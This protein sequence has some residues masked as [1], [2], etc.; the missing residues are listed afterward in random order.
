MAL[1]VSANAN[2]VNIL[3]PGSNTIGVF[4]VTNNI[5]TGADMANFLTV[6]VI[7]ANGSTS[8]AIWMADCGALCGEAHN[9]AGT[10]SIGGT[11][12]PQWM[13]T[14]TDN[15]DNLNGFPP[16][17]HATSTWTLTNSASDPNFAIAA[18]VL[19]GNSSVV[20][21]RAP[22]NNFDEGTPGSSY[23]VDFNVANTV[24]TG[25]GVTVSV[26]YD[27]RAFLT[28]VPGTTNCNGAGFTGLHT[29][30]PGCGDEFGKITFA[31]TGGPA[32]IG[33]TVTPIIS[34]AFFTDT[35]LVGSPEPVT[36][37]LIGTGLVALVAFRKRFA[38]RP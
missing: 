3:S 20:F 1:A 36:F 7:F 15:T 9:T 5:T 17:S 10:L 19:N 22:L 35:D 29:G 4:S 32:F 30:T 38:R 8:N 16:N 14:E 37:G 34:F 6:Q 13:L 33:T 11:L 24:N 25:T 26:T 31:F 23:G 21:D 27:N 28:G 12:T 18:V 2:T